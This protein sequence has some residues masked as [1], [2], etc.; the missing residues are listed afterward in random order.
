V[1]GEVR[2]AVFRPDDDRLADAVSLLESLGATPVPD[3]MLEVEPTG[4]TPESADFVVFTSKTGAELVAEAGWEPGA[5]TVVCAIGSSTA[6]AL[7]EAGYRVDRVPEQFSS[8]GLV[9]ELA[10]E[11]AG[12]SV[13]VARSDHGSTV[14]LDGLR[15]A[16]ADVNETVLYR[17]VRP[18]GSGESAAMAAGGDLEAAVFTS[19]MTVENFLAA[20]AE[21]GVREAATAGLNDAVVGVIGEPT[22][23]TAEGLGIDVDV[24]PDRA[25]FEELACAVVERAAPSYT[26]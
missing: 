11:V 14:L 18:A 10:D 24:V 1:T 12:A 6:A 17:L 20:A 9:D 7:R 21:Q 26:D 25:D 16:G 13:E 5:E 4:A 2:V 23:T 22:R 8:A 3:P 19:S 15:E